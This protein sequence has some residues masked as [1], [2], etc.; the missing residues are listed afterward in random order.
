M[1]DPFLIII[2][3]EPLGFIIES[4]IPVFSSHS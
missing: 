2:C 1:A 4:P 3:I